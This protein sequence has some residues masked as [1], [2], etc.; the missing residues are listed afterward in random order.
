MTTQ[1]RRTLAA[2]A[3]ELRAL[4]ESLAELA[5]LDEQTEPA[6]GEVRLTLRRAPTWTPDPA[7]VPPTPL[8]HADP[9][10]PR[11]PVCG[12][13]LVLVQVMPQVE[14]EPEAAT[15]YIT[16]ACAPGDVAYVWKCPRGPHAGG[17]S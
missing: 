17:Q 8:T 16:P 1:D 15:L 14:E 5:T 3:A 11:C 4:A 2:V 7:P 12:G 10:R 6:A 9:P 13:W